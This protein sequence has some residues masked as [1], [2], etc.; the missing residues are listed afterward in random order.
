[1][2][3]DREIEN[4]R[5]QWGSLAE[6]LPETRLIREKIKR[7][8]R[9]F[10]LDNVRE[11]VAVLVGLYLA[12]YVKQHEYLLGTG[13]GIAVCVVIFVS[14]GYQIW[15]QRGVWRAEAQSTRAFLELW[16]RRVVAKIR[17]LRF[18][19]YLSVVWIFVCI[20]LGIANWG[21]LGP[22]LKSHPASWIVTLIASLFGLPAIF[23][24]ATWLKRRKVAELNEVTKI[25]ADLR[26]LP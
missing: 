20:A 7:Q 3:Q 1:M 15:F 9:R 10:I 18:G 25:L 8:E 19:V 24:W 4:W 17:I 22:N 21:T 5:E 14:A 2:T 11:T 23:A 6:P 12:F 13:F 26:D 16:Q